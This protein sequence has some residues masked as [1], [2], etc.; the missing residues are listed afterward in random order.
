MISHLNVESNPDVNIM[1]M[2]SVIEVDRIG[3]A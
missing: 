3:L 2:I 1:R